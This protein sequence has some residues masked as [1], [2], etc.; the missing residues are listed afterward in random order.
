[1]SLLYTISPF[2]GYNKSKINSVSLSRVRA[3]TF[4]FTRPLFWTRLWYSNCAHARPALFFIVRATVPRALSPIPAKTTTARVLSY[5]GI[6]YTRGSAHRCAGARI[7]ERA[8]LRAIAR[9]LVARLHMPLSSC[10]LMHSPLVALSRISL[11]PLICI[12]YMRRFTSTAPA[13]GARA[14]NHA[15]SNSCL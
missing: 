6:P 5:I 13:R 11:S 9:P 7:G 15:I 1:M 3:A 8:S 4:S 14:P 10:V 12:M 2:Q